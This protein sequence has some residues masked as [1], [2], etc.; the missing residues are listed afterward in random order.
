MTHDHWLDLLAKIKSTCKNVTEDVLPLLDGGGTEIANGTLTVVEFDAPTRQHMKLEMQKKP[1]VLSQ[2]QSF[3]GRAGT[4]A[5][6]HYDVSDTE[7]T[8]HVSLYMEDD[9]GDW[10]NVPIENFV[11]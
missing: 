3:S 2:S 1:R 8:F 11:G 10:V 4:S 5:Q 6:V 7:F 9:Y